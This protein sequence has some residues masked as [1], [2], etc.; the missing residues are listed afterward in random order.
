MGKKTPNGPFCVIYALAICVSMYICGCVYLQLLGG[1]LGQQEAIVSPVS[2]V[3]Q[4]GVHPASPQNKD[5]R[6]TSRPC[7]QE[8]RQDK[9]FRYKGNTKKYLFRS[10]QLHCLQ[11]F[12]LFHLFLTFALSPRWRWNVL[13]CQDCPNHHPSPGVLQDTG[14][15]CQA[16]KREQSYKFH[17]GHHCIAH[18]A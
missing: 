9:R 3:R 2:A 11:P 6:A 16:M 17:T 1:V 18:T 10:S 14:G 4:P 12:E 15:P 7:P 5:I 8:Q 13:K